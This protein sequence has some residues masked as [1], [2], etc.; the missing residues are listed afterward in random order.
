MRR[1][2][3]SSDCDLDPRTWRESY[4]PEA[5]VSHALDRYAS[6]HAEYGE[7]NKCEQVAEDDEP[8]EER[9]GGNRHGVGVGAISCA[10]RGAEVGQVRGS[11]VA[12]CPWEC[13]LH[14]EFTSALST[15]V[16]SISRM[17]R[18]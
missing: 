4:A 7:D 18:A 3:N 12:A 2:P 11:V 5:R 1:E 17:S 14:C 16:R 8:D 15:G 13:E 9:D 10:C 6:D